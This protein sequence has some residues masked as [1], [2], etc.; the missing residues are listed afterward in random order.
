MS[1]AVGF[2]VFL[3]KASSEDIS[4]SRKVSSGIAETASARDTKSVKD[5]KR[6]LS[7]LGIEV[8]CPSTL[9]PDG[10]PSVRWRNLAWVEGD[11][12]T[13]LGGHVTH[14]S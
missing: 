13:D 12:L 3:S 2:Q 4:L 11:T 10:C 14:N 9:N 1:L 7:I 8:V 5:E 6:H